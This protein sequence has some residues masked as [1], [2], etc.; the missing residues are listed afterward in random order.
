MSEL[1][2]VK[3]IEGKGRG[4][5]ASKFIKKG[6]LILKHFVNPSLFNHSCHPNALTGMDKPPWMEDCTGQEVRAIFDIEPGQE[7]TIPYFYGLVLLG[8]RKKEF[9]Q[10]FVLDQASFTCLCYLCQKENDDDDNANQSKIEELIEEMRKLKIK[11][12]AAD[13]RRGIDCCKQLYKLGK[14]K[15]AQPLY[16]YEIL[17][18]GFQA[19]HGGHMLC[20]SKPNSK[21]KLELMTEFAKECVNF[22]KAAERFGKIL[23]KE[24]VK[25][26]EW[27]KRHQ[28]IDQYFLNTWKNSSTSEI[29]STGTE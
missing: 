13:C 4:I 12:D 21:E 27:R 2:Q 18:M 6:T 25:P 26:E 20:I 16:L 15:K 23:G 28:N 17:D 19:A 1:F 10:K 22:A 29:T 3:E 8:M 7:I 11:T 24:V 9:R 5:L 14:D